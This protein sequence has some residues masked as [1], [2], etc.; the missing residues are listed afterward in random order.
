MRELQLD[1]DPTLGRRAAL[2]AAIRGAIRDGR[3]TRGTVVPSTRALAA[4]LGCSRATVVAAYD[5]LVAE[6][7][8]LAEQGRSTRVAAVHA[9]ETPARDHNPLGP[10][11]DH[12]FRPGEPDPSSFPRREWLRSLR[13]VMSDAPDDV[14]GYA[15]PRGHLALRSALADHLG[16]TRSVVAHPSA[17]QV[18]PGF[19]A[20]L[21]FLGE[22]FVRHGRGRIAVEDPMLFFHRDVLRVVGVEIVP[23]AVDDDG[24]RTD[25]LEGL[26]VDAV[27]VCAAHQY[28]LGGA[29]AP[30]RRTR[31]VEWAET[32]DTWIIEDDYDGEFRY[33]RRPVGAL[34]ALAPDRVVHCGTASKTLG[35]GLRLAWLTVPPRLRSRV[36]RTVHLRA[37]VPSVDQ[38]ALADLIE[39]GA[40]DRHVRNVRAR[41]ARRRTQLRSGL[42]DVPWLDLSSHEAGLHLTAR[43]TEPALDETSIIAAAATASIGLLGLEPH[44]AEATTVRERGLVLGV[45][46]IPEHRFATGLDRLLAVLHSLG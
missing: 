11:F 7:F 35:A 41:Y 19:V 45:S 14:F 28:P 17:V 38:L 43:L 29:L 27:L 39:R 30:E 4:D 32:T 13:R 8:L 12:D 31:L 46:R 15:D 37:G 16:R 33:D 42:A 34:Q 44:Y 26:E 10:T 18:V 40:L 1:L 20:G 9:P 24:L 23:V 25:L 21:A 2:E 5:Q 6:G 3:L 36:G 22:L